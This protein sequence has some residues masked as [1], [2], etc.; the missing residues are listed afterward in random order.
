VESEASL[1]RR[2]SGH[3]KPTNGPQPERRA[4][5]FD[6]SR[7][8]VASEPDH[9]DSHVIDRS[10]HKID[11][12]SC[13]ESTVS[14]SA[15]VQDLGSVTPPL[16]TPTCDRVVFKNRYSGAPESPPPRHPAGFELTPRPFGRLMQLATEQTPLQLTVPYIQLHVTMDTSIVDYSE[17]RNMWVAIEATVKTHVVDLP[18]E[19]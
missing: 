14:T 10:V 12:R 9:Q 3:R 1:L 4:Y 7:N 15:L 8:S 19:G 16:G 6:V 13:T 2:I 5:S 17:K 18:I 11:Q